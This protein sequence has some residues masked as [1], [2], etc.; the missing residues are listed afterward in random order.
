M[1]MIALLVSTLAVYA[2]FFLKQQ[3]N[4]SIVN[5][6]QRAT[7]LA[8]SLAIASE[9]AIVVGDLTAIE[10]LVVRHAEYPFVNHVIVTDHAGRI[11]SQV[12]RSSDGAMKL[13]YSNRLLEVPGNSDGEVRIGSVGIEIWHP[14]V[15]DHVRGWVNIDLGLNEIAALKKRM[16]W[17][18]VLAGGV[19]S[20]LTAMIIALL[21]RPHARLLT[22]ASKFAAN[23]DQNLGNQLPVGGSTREFEELGNALNHASSKLARQDQEIRLQRDQLLDNL[24]ELGQATE[25]LRHKNVELEIE[26]RRREFL[27]NEL[28]SKNADLERFN[29]AVSHDLKSPLVTIRGFVGLLEKDLKENDRERVAEDLEEIE[30]AAQRMSHLLDGLLNLARLGRQSSSPEA[31]NLVELA[32]IA[33]EQVAGRID[34]TNA[35]I[36]IDKNLPMV[37]GDRITMQEVMLNLIDNAVKFGLRDSTRVEITALETA[38][39]VGCCVKDNGIGI[40]RKYHARVFDL[41]ERLDPQTEGTGIGLALVKRGIEE[42]KG[43]VWVESSGEGQGTSMCFLIPR[44]A[45]ASK[46]RSGDERADAADL[47][48]L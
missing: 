23:L 2:W 20:I 48:L 26:A 39:E 30:K 33:V 3:A 9:P 13:A 46:N 47:D 25:Q 8:Q 6:Q 28:K 35:Q 45:V 17:N 32:E 21:V 37:Y 4:I 38:D 10:H 15:V 12:V 43:R 7:F 41:F 11:L 19:I 31:L 40:D 14:I 18:A 5:T 44:Q 1:L 36:S 27:I 16:W 24:Q 29:Y 34:E 22:E 42:H